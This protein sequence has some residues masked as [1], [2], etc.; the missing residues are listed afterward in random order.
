[1]AIK[2]GNGLSIGS[3]AP[4]TIGLCLYFLGLSL[5]YG[6]QGPPVMVAAGDQVYCP[7]TP[8]AVATSFSITHADQLGLEEFHIQISAGY[9]RGL[10]RL[11]LSG[12]H[13]GIATGWNAQ[14]GKLTLR[15]PVPGQRIPYGEIDSAVLG[16]LFQ[17]DQGGSV[18]EKHFSFTFGDA[19]YLPE[20]GH[21]YQYISAPGIPWDQ[22][23][24]AAANRKYYGLQG[25]LATI[26][27]QAEAQLSGEQAAGAGWIGGSDAGSEGVWRWMT[28][29][30]QGQIFWNGSA[31]GSSPNFAFWNWEEPNNL[32]DEDYAHVTAP[33][34]GRPGT[35][36]DLPLIGGV[37]DYEPKG[38]IVEYGGMVGDPPLTLSASTRIRIPTIV[39]TIP[40]TGC[41]AG[42]LTLTANTARAGDTA[43]WFDAQ[44][45]QVHNG[46]SFTT[47]ILE[48]STTYYVLASHDGCTSG[49]RLPVLATVLSVPQINDGLRVTNCEVAEGAGTTRFDLGQYLH[50]LSPDHGRLDFTFY[51][52]RADA[53]NATNALGGEVVGDFDYGQASQLFFRAAGR[54]EFCHAV[55]RMDLGVSTVSLP[56]GYR[57]ELSRCELG[58]GDGR[59]VFDLRPV[60]ADIR[61]QFPGSNTLTVSFYE[62]EADALLQRN[63]IENL[64]AYPNATPYAQGLFVRVDDPGTGSCFGLGEHLALTV[65]PLPSFRVDGEYIICLGGSVEVAAV[66]PMEGY[67]YSW[68]D[69]AHTQI[70]TGPSIS[71]SQAGEYSVVGTTAANCASHPLPFSVVESGPP[72]LAP[73]FVNVGFQG[74]SGSITVLHENGELGPGDYRF[75][76]DGPQAQWQESAVFQ[77]LAPGMHT[78]LAMDAQGCG[79]DSMRVGVI[80]VPK[81]MTP[82][83]DGF[84]DGIMVL[85]VSGEFYAQ[86]SFRIFD[87]FGSVLAQLDPMQESWDGTHLGRP[88]PPSDYWY[89]LELIDH[90]GNPI[91]R[92]GHFTLKR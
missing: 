20:T 21:Y 44:G 51:W 5:L 38:Y 67:T 45:N 11:E 83:H 18:E 47:P 74:D 39:E 4:L 26:T 87:R 24:D 85:G 81:F 25:Y 71:I 64:A 80:G 57:R 1:M 30:E 63:K 37:G 43:L 17:A 89:V 65:L 77:N 8:I 13:P 23:R 66:D 7:G 22:A 46:K 6:Q 19:N 14:E 54:G 86:G 53:E 2:I 49:E 50:L 92:R 70:G 35:W 16:V 60:E 79:M 76:L 36:N 27:S 41:G 32:G 82:N 10:D 42:S 15:S 48:V 84:N 62:R 34:V 68:F 78:L 59:A 28:G 73:E 69:S 9:E 40:A 55:G 12:T 88:L 31:A 56:P 52:N 33:G 75:A 61:A 29:P 72:T 91:L 90:Q 3:G 58:A